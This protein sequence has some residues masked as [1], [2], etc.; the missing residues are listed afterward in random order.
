MP[1][2]P[3]FFK[4][5]TVTPSSKDDKVRGQGVAYMALTGFMVLTGV[6]YMVLTGAHWLHTWCSLIMP[7][8]VQ[9]QPCAH[10]SGG[11]SN[12]DAVA[13]AASDQGGVG[14]VVPYMLHGVEIMLPRAKV[15]AV[16][17]ACEAMERDE[18][19]RKEHL[20]LHGAAALDVCAAPAKQPNGKVDNPVF[21]CRDTGTCFSTQEEAG[22]AKAQ[23]QEAKVSRSLRVRA[24]IEGTLA[25]T[26]LPVTMFMQHMRGT[27]VMSLAC[28]DLHACGGALARRR[29]LCAVVH[30]CTTRQQHCFCWRTCIAYDD[31]CLV[32][33]CVRMHVQ[34]APPH[35][36]GTLFPPSARRSASRQRRSA[37]RQR[38]RQGARPS[39]ATATRRATRLWGRRERRVGATA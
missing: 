26:P 6:A 19:A 30:V 5:H 1:S 15:A 29:S 31:V 27:R 13:P 32:C 34:D 10:G 39:S 9:V 3:Q 12:A 17:Q 14:E 7:F 18:A 8:T 4:K 22:R 36:V 11:G 21:T 33:A 23:R 2:V 37:R 24:V 20:E 16:S 25:Y 35:A 28:M 38:Q